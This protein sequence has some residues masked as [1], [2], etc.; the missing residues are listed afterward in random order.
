MR[1]I[2]FVLGIFAFQAVIFFYH[3]PPYLF[4]K[5][6]GMGAVFWVL[7]PCTLWK[8]GT[9]TN[10]KRWYVTSPPARLRWKAMRGSSVKTKHQDSVPQPTSKAGPALPHSPSRA[11]TQ[12]YCQW[13]QHHFN[14][15]HH[16]AT[17][18]SLADHKYGIS[19]ISSWVLNKSSFLEGKFPV[20]HLIAL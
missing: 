14:P 6:P 1:G 12:A 7:A 17:K 3:L 4:P 8:S 5:L 9:Y 13:C 16:S 20:L 2:L 11:C 19:L 18:Q 15:C 10:F